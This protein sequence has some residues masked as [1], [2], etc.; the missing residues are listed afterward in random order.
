MRLKQG[1]ILWINLDSAKGTETK[2]KRSRLV[3]ST[4]HYNRYFNTALVV[5]INT[6]DKYRT[7][8]KYVKSPLF[9]RIDKGE[10]QGTALLQ[11]VC[12]VDP[13]ERSNGKVVVI[14]SQQEISTIRTAVQQFF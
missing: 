3:V 13:T 11:H 8:E 1:A 5:P 10:I 12:A 4:D 7:L 2:K 6:S 14:L 9:I